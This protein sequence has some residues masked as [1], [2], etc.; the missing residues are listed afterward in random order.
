MLKDRTKL[1]FQLEEKSLRNRENI[2]KQI[3]TLNEEILEIANRKK[4]FKETIGPG[5]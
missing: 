4:K 3:E 1:H 2:E 5:A